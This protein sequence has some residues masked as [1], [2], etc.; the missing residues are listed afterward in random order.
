MSTGSTVDVV[1]VG[2]GIVGMAA[3][4]ELAGAGASVVLVER[5]EIG[6]GA[7]GRNSGILWRP[8]DRVLD[9]LYVETLAILRELAAE[10][11]AAFHVPDQPVGILNLSHD[12]AGMRRR[13]SELARSH[14]QYAPAFLDPASLHEAEPGLAGGLSAV[15]LDIGFP[16]GPTSATRAMAERA[17]TRGA[18]V[19]E[20]SAARVV[21]ESGRATGV[22]SDGRMVAAGSVVVAAGPWTPEVIDPSGRWRPIRPFWGV[23][24]ELELDEPPRHVL[25]GAGIDAAI[26]PARAIGEDDGDEDDGAVDFSLVTFSGRSSLGSTF[27]PFEPDPTAYVERLRAIGARYLPAI[28]DTPTLGLRACARPLAF[29]GRPLVGAVPGVERLFVAAGHGPWGLSTGAASGRH[30]ACDVLGTR[31][32]LP[33]AIREAVDPARYPAP[34]L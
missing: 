17:R 4:A 10:R 11:P 28:A 15:R 20:G 30:I 5:A 18:R 29:D 23:V 24:V 25:E 14:P 16:V 12:Q 26:D 31:D 2:G 32:P 27:L 33:A 22:A 13:A 7:S 21:I 34:A 8:P 6:A 19:T 1:V 9:A 3:A